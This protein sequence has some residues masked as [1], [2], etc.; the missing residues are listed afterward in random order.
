MRS[1]DAFL[2]ISD[3]GGSGNLQNLEKYDDFIDNWITKMITEHCVDSYDIPCL[4]L[5]NK[6]DLVLEQCQQEDEPM[7]NTPRI[8]KL[9][10]VSQQYGIKL[11]LGSARN[12]TIANSKDINSNLLNTYCGI[13][14]MSPTMIFNEL[15]VMVC[16]DRVMKEYKKQDNSKRYYEWLTQE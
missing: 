2:I 1:A 16:K 5:G 14:I 15:A 7:K 11:V 13:E 6:L 10:Q 12:P 3:M 4:I 8:D 9:K